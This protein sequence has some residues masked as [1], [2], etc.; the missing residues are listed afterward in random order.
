MAERPLVQ[1]SYFQYKHHK[2][3]KNGGNAPSPCYL[4]SATQVGSKFVIYGGCGSGDEHLSQLFLY[5]SVKFVWSVPADDSQ[6]QVVHV[7]YLYIEMSLTLMMIMTMM[8]F[9]IVRRTTQGSATHIV[10]RWWRCTHQK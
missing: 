6:Y 3:K 1:W 9:S 8:M 7:H 5:D 10:P 4:H 2:S